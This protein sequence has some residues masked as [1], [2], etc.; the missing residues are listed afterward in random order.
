MTIAHSLGFPRIGRERQM[1]F[2]I[3]SYWQGTINNETLLEKGRAIRQENW[4]LQKEAGLALLPVGDFSWYDHV[5]D[6]SLMLGV[7]P[8]RFK[9]AE[10]EQLKTYFLM[11]RG[12]APGEKNV[13]PCEMTKWFNTNYHYIVPELHPAQQFFL[14]SDKLFNEIKEA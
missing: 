10:R 13:R 2:A 4:A 1:K 7:I 9:S 8:E 11:A 6:M 3:E 12:Q 14:N 5:L